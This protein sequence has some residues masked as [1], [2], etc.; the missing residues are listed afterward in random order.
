[1]QLQA[2]TIKQITGQLQS[3]TAA[4]NEMQQEQ[5]LQKKRVHALRKML[6]TLKERTEA[7]E[8]SSGVC[9]TE[10]KAVQEGVQ[11]LSG[12]MDALYTDMNALVKETRSRGAQMKAE[13]ERFFWDA[14]EERYQNEQNE[15]DTMW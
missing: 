2:N 4:Q 12:D 10:L 13:M 11:V 6:I 14:A 8:K 9:Q 1:M 7:L 5:L 3:L 15:S